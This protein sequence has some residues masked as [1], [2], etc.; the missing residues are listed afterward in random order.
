L[1]ALLGPIAEALSAWLLAFPN[2][3]PE[4]VPKLAG[5]VSLNESRPKGDLVVLLGVAFKECCIDPD[6]NSDSP[7]LLGVAPNKGFGDPDPNSP[8]PN[9]D[10][11][12]LFG[13]VSEDVWAA[14]E[15]NIP[16][17]GN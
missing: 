15:P 8:P 10:S 16:V 14:E 17:V 13:V 3:L 12:D 11:T 6:P 7:G 2:T 1:A 4:S 5:G 9:R